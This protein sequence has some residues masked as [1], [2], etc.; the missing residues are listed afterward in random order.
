[1]TDTR[2][3]IEHPLLTFTYLWQPTDNFGGQCDRL[4]S[5]NYINNCNYR[6]AY[7]MLNF[8][9]SESMIAPPAGQSILL[10]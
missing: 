1:M 2:A 3:L 9:Y 5:D 8:L 6:G 7:Q 10:I 4:N